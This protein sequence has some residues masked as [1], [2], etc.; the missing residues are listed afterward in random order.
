MFLQRKKQ[1]QQRVSRK[2]QLPKDIVDHWPEVF[3]DLDI[4]VVPIDY[5]HS[6]RIYFT[7]GRVWDVD[8]NKTKKNKVKKDIQS[9]L[10]EHFREYEN[11]IENID[12]RLDTQRIKTDIQRRTSS[13]IK[14]R[15]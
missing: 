13:F 9:S 15:R 5:L 10:E 14:K 6:V 1:R 7:D 8:V 12:F 4:S 3:K 11:H 2:K